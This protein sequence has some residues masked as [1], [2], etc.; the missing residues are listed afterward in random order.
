MNIIKAHLLI[1]LA[2]FDT[3]LAL[4]QFLNFLYAGFQNRIEFTH[5]H[6]ITT[7][8]VEKLAMLRAS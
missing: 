7:A 3:Q 6:M 4:P 1:A 5:L 8:S 2:E